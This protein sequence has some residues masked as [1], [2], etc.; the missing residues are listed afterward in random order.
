MRKLLALGAFLLAFAVSAV[1]GEIRVSPSSIY[2]GDVESFLTVYGTGFTEA[3]LV[4]IDGPGGTFTLEVSS[5]HG[6]SGD[7]PT[8]AISISVPLE[9]AV[10]AGDYNVT[11][12][13]P[14]ASGT[15]HDGPATF[16]VIGSVVP[17]PPS[18]FVPEALAVDATSP[19]GAVV[20]FEVSAISFV[21]PTPPVVTCNHE[22]GELYPIG[23]TLVTCSATDSFGTA[24]ASFP[25]FVQDVGQPTLTL[26]ADIVSASHVVTWTASATDA[27]DGSVPVVCSPASG[28]TF[29]TGTT[30]VNCSAADHQLNTAFGSFTVTVVEGPPHVYLPA[31]I[32][33]EATSPAG[34]VVEYEATT[35]PGATINCSPASG[36]TF[37]LGTTTVNCTATNPLGT[38]SGSFTVTVAD[39]TPP[40][41]VSIT[42]SP[43]VLWSPDHKMRAVTI[44]VVAYD[45]ADLS[46]TSHIVSVTSSQPVVGK[47]SG[48]TTVD[49]TITGPLTL[50]LRAERAGGVDRVYTIT[51]ETVDASGNKTQST[52]TVSVQQ[53]PS[54]NSSH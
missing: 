41:I 11:V 23:N 37:A 35:D 2:V 51:V 21:D 50:Q 29:A 17:Q 36:S 46:P 39:T 6:P 45:A 7:D 34:A 40:Q 9:V 44:T 3:S 19:S 33:A 42:A 16:T 47:G 24:Q 54:A 30:T 43:S 13:T 25:I 1:A 32:T 14:T 28:S 48:S 10:S 18:I 20:T 4:T 15:Q 8:V 26:P 27:V 49:W 52:V 22:S 12:D 5:I 53:Q 31:N 38:A